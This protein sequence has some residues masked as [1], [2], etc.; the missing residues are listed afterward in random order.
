[1]KKLG[2]LFLLIATLL[3][4]QNSSVVKVMDD[5]TNQEFEFKE[6]KNLDNG[7][8]IKDA[9]VDNVIYK[10]IGSKYYKRVIP[11][12]T[13]DVTWFGTNSDAIQK[14]VDFVS[15]DLGP[16]KRAQYSI[17]LPEGTYTIDKPIKIINTEG[18]R[19]SGGGIG[20]ILKIKKDTHISSVLDLNGVA[21]G[22]F[23]NFY[24]A[25]DTNSS[26]DSFINMYWADKKSDVQA[27]N[28]P[29]RSSTQ[30]SFTNIR[31][32]SGKFKNAVLIDGHNQNDVSMW[33]NVA[34][35]GDWN[36]S[37]KQFYQSAFYI[38]DGQAG[39]NL[40]HD[41][42][43]VYLVGVKSG[44]VFAGSSGTITGGG[45]TN[46]DTYIV[47]NNPNQ[48][49]WISGSRLEH[50]KRIYRN[51]GAHDGIHE[52]PE[53]VTFQSLWYSGSGATQKHFQPAEDGVL[54]FHGG[55]TMNIIGSSIM[56]LPDNYKMKIKLSGAMNDNFHNALNII[57]SNIQGK[58]DEIFLVDKWAKASVNVVG[59]N[60]IGGSLG[61]KM[62]K[63]V[64][65]WQKD[66]N[67][68]SG[69]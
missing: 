64:H 2:F 41:F 29:Q 61:T 47:R 6:V 25:G 34:F 63:H 43:N 13:V 17:Y 12:K 1:M 42:R 62:G 7:S 40:L 30:N 56:Y 54:I 37:E 44:Y 49:L 9:Q 11:N 14:A 10:K 5:V 39:N 18:I 46:I 3:H 58:F 19:I 69:K 55:G 28:L 52:F 4:S 20:T 24:F 36:P 8:V 38:G 68:S 16:W 23:E 26:C 33:S 59:S 66:F 67:Y 51:E 60:E 21:Y 65:Q 35:L 32:L 22:V 53:N 27:K 45:C 48:T 50:T 57:G 15:L 31:N